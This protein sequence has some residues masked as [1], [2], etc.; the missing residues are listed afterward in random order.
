[1]HDQPDDQRQDAVPDSDDRPVLVVDGGNPRA[2]MYQQIADVHRQLVEA[3]WQARTT[4]QP[5]QVSPK[6]L[7]HFDEAITFL[8]EEVLELRKQVEKLEAKAVDCGS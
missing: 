4:K 2:A 6:I 1:M 7:F 3:K 8:A 5:M